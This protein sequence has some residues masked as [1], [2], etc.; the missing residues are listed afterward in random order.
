MT[1]LTEWKESLKK[2]IEEAGGIRGFILVGLI[3][4]IIM[5]FVLMYLLIIRFTADVIR[6]GWKLAWLRLF[7][8][9][10][11]EDELLRIDKEKD[12]WPEDPVERAKC[13][14]LNLRHENDFEFLTNDKQGC[15]ELIYVANEEDVVLNDMFINHPEVLEEIKRITGY[16]V[17]YL[18]SLIDQL[19]NEEIFRYMTPYADSFNVRFPSIGNDYMLQFLVHPED[20]ERMKHGLLR[21]EGTYRIDHYVNTYIN[22]FYPLSSDGEETIEEQ[23]RRIGHQIY[24]ETHQPCVYCKQKDTAGEE[25]EDFADNQ[26]VPQ[27]NWESTEEL[28]DE[29]R[30]RVEKLRQRGIA[31][32]ILEKILHPDEKYSR[33][34]ITKD[35]RIILPD[36][37]NMEI[38]MEPLVKAVYLLFLSHPDGI[39][40]KDL[41]SHKDELTDIY[42]KLKPNGLT[43]RIRKSIDDVTNPLLNSINE[44]CARIRGAFVGKFDNDLAD[45]YYINGLRAEPKKIY[46]SQELIIWEE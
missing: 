31:Q 19:D 39:R 21:S 1:K 34:V 4:L 22:Q 28:L 16:S 40:F 44:K 27:I 25:P 13:P 8:P 10:A 3:T 30:E 14:R 20:R 36:Y 32:S 43:D 15:K 26:F 38:H 17:V 24:E 6:K 11:Y 45:N 42:L 5:P 41:P 12:G 7:D 46:L 35:Y 29:I 33:L 23:L 18:P 9:K 2:E 37:H